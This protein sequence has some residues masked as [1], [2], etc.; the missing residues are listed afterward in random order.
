M[1][2]YQYA[3]HIPVSGLPRIPFTHADCG[4]DVQP[5]TPRGWTGDIFIDEMDDVPLLF[6]FIHREAFAGELRRL[7]AKRAKMAKRFDCL[8]RQSTMRSANRFKRAARELD[9]NE[10]RTE[11]LRDLLEV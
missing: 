7:R 4:G 3:Y 5:S 10:D 2:L 11:R 9:H 1:K 6:S 8:W